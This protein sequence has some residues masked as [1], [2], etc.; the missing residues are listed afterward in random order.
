VF[1]LGKMVASTKVS[2]STTRN[3]EKAF[4]RGLTVE[5]TTGIGKTENRMEKEII[6]QARERPRKEFGRMV[7]G[8]SG[9]KKI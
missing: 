1:S 4:S 5:S 6:L 8:F 3:T 7:S 9:P 2:I